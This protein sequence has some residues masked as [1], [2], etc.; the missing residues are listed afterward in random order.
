MARPD[1]VA[2]PVVA[3]ER[4][5]ARANGDAV[6]RAVARPASLRTAVVTAELLGAPRAL[7]P[8]GAPGPL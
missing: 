1:R 7:R 5:V 8:Y 3:V 4:S 2:R 6:R